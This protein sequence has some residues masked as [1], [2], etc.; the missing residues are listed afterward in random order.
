MA[1]YCQCCDRYTATKI[2][3][4]SH[5]PNKIEGHFRIP[6]INIS[7]LDNKTNTMKI[8]RR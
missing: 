7:D 6:Y 3:E 4:V 2:N 1:N 8:I 5:I